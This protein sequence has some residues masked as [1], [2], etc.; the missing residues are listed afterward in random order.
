M[1]L[2]MYLLLIIAGLCIAVF[3]MIM[4]D[5]FFNFTVIPGF[6]E[7][8][9]LRDVIIFSV[10]AFLGAGLSVFGVVRIIRMNK[11]FPGEVAG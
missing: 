3:G 7:V 5:W 10:I 6:L 2:L 11:R 4:A 1:K 9:F 8:T